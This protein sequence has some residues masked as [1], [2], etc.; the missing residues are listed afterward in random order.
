MRSQRQFPTSPFLLGLIGLSFCLWVQLSGGKA[1]CLTDG[2]ALF[3]DFSLAGVSLWLAGSSFFGVMLLLCVLRF[4]SFAR[5]CA[6]IALAADILLM[7]VMSQRAW[8]A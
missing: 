1:L 6:G 3:Q 4:S 7:A 5:F 8:A 2:C